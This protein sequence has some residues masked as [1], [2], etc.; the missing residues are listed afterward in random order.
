MHRFFIDK[1]KINGN[2]VTLE[3]E[4]ASHIY[5]VLRLRKG[6]TVEL[7]DGQGMD[8]TAKLGKV[9]GDYVEAYIQSRFQ[10]QG[11]PGL[12]TTLYQAI[13]KGSKMD[14]IV[15]K[16]V[17]L[18]V[19]QIVPIITVR[20]IVKLENTKSQKR[21][22]ERWQRIA[23]E[24]AKQS[25]RGIIP[26]VSPPIDFRQALQS[27]STALRIFLW[28]E[29][30]DMGL[31]KYLEEVLEQKTEVAIMVGPEGG[32]EEQEAYEA[33]DFGWNIISLGPRILR[34]ETVGMS[35][36]SAI[37]FYAGEMQ[38]KTH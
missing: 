8:Y 38:W 1:S 5:K 29:E 34:T 28:E 7:C 21:K 3:Q 4:D 27:S 23:Q 6:D 14:I 11:E 31:K 9:S 36:L 37:M 20:T 17:E 19:S 15:Q 35:V 2:I 22:V 16:C 24:A 33:R 30:R 10:T 12:K 32:W 26:V 25:R 13:P 18:G